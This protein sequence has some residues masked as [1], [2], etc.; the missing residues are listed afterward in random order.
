M[1]PGEIPQKKILIID[2][3]EMVRFL[4]GE[5]LRQCGFQVECAA[6]G[7][8]GVALYRQALES[9]APFYAVFLDLN[10]PGGSGGSEIFKQ[11]KIIDPMVKAFVSSGDTYDPLM[12]DYRKY[13]FC[14][15]VEKPYF[16]LKKDIAAELEKAIA[17]HTSLQS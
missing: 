13:G 15:I 8:A 16:Y 5:K 2:D 14:G 10:I 4:A 1:K 17:A 11:I 9:E 6:D 7:D 12:V 3:D